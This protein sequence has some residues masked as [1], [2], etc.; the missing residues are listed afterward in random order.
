M[1]EKYPPGRSER[2]APSLA[3]QQLYADLQFEI[4]NLS[5][6]R[7]LGSMQPP[8]GGICEAALLSDCN[9][10]TQMTKFHCNRPM[11]SRHISITQS[12]C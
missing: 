6:K 8:F 10:I 2:N 5:A 4:A 12:I 9:E 1:I 11:L 3:L 7:W